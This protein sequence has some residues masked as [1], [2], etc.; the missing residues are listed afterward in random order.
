MGNTSTGYTWALPA[1]RG[2]EKNFGVTPSWLRDWQVPSCGVRRSRAGS[3]SFTSH[4]QWGSL[5]GLGHKP[6]VCPHTGGW[7]RG[8]LHP[9]G[10]LSTPAG[11][12]LTR[13]HHP[14]PRSARPAPFLA[15]AAP[16]AAPR[17]PPSAC[18][19]QETAENED[20][21]ALAGSQDSLD[22]SKM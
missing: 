16:A 12:R 22:G 2:A 14:A 21:T 3:S 10:Q 19:W 13:R 17:Y 1:H 20:F 8:D 4:T 6:D 5:P 9:A 11:H 18:R 7:E 15:C